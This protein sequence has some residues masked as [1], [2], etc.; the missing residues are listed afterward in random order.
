V[1]HPVG[2]CRCSISTMCAAPLL[3]LLPAS[4][5][6]GCLCT[7][8]HHMHLLVYG[9]CV[10][11]VG[12]WGVALCRLPPKRGGGLC[13]GVFVVMATSRHTGPPPHR[14]L[15]STCQQVA[16]RYQH[17]MGHVF[18]LVVC[19]W[20]QAAVFWCLCYQRASHHLGCSNVSARYA[21]A[22]KAPWRCGS[23]ACCSV[24]LAGG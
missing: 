15:A 14:P 18:H 23:V 6:A 20:M 8:Q 12:L 3:H 19:Q 1:E 9:V 2:G 4:S 22:A 16:M 11:R 24:A 21:T 13:G 5:V 17:S 7:T 10:S